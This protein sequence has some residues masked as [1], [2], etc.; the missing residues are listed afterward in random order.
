MAAR[1]TPFNGYVEG[2]ITDRLQTNCSECR[3]G[4]FE[5]QPRKWTKNGLIHPWCDYEDSQ[6]EGALPEQR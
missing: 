3:G 1:K 5:N 6:L 4:I 2:K